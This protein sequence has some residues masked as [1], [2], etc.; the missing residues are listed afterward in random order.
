[1][2]AFACSRGEPCRIRRGG[3]NA[4]EHS[5][6]FGLCGVVVGY[7][8]VIAPKRGATSEKFGSDST[9]DSEPILL[10]YKRFTREARI[11]NQRGVEVFLLGGP[12]IISERHQGVLFKGCQYSIDSRADSGRR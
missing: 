2:L 8:L 1:M 9:L 5:A 3:Y 11:A 4:C 7:G 12:V 10:N 6:T